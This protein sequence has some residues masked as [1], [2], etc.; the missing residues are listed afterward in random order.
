MAL[1]QPITRG[2]ISE[3]FGREISGDALGS[4]KRD[5]L[6]ATGPRS[7]RP[8]APPTYVTTQRFL[9]AFGLK[10]L[11]DLPGFLDAQEIGGAEGSGREDDDPFADAEVADDVA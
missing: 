10:R 11:S 5:G 2:E 3:L 4:L 7:P 6:L 1:H 9:L 8:G